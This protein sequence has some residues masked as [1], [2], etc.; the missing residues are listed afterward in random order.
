MYTK[1][2][3]N[4]GGVVGRNIKSSGQ[5]SYKIVLTWGEK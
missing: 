3:N 4:I 1:Y 2:P 5:V